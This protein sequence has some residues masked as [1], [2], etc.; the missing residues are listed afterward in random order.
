MRITPEPCPGTSPICKAGYVGNPGPSRACS[1]Q[2]VHPSAARVHAC[3]DALSR[4]G[5]DWLQLCAFGDVAV[6]Q[7]PP[8]S[9]RE[10]SRYRDDRNASR[11]AVRSR[12]L[13]APVEPLGEGAAGLVA[14]PGPCHLHQERADPPGTLF[15][16]HLGDVALVAIVGQV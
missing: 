15:T 3:P 13:G 8:Q 12:A 9:N 2:T 4:C 10:T 7:I 11:A 5:S 1:L 14:Q 16:D 6:L